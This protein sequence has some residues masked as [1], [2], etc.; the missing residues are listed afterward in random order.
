M[1]QPALPT[2]RRGQSGAQGEGEPS[3]TPESTSSTHVPI[4]GGTFATAERLE[5]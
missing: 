3:L 1:L 4:F 2:V 5:N